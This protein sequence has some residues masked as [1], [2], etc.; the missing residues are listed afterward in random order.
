[1]IHLREQTV[2]NPK[3]YEAVNNYAKTNRIPY[4]KAIRRIAKLMGYAHP[5][6]VYEII[7]GFIPGWQKQSKFCQITGTTWDEVW[8]EVTK[9]ALS[10][11]PGPKR[12]RKVAAR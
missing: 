2:G 8:G 4:P 1:V 3:A 6:R 11:E 12:T 9:L 5:Q 7:Q 10:D